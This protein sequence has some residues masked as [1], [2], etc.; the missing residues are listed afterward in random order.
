MFLKNANI[1]IKN[2]LG[3]LPSDSNALAASDWSADGVFPVSMTGKSFSDLLEKNFVYLES[4]KL[5]LLMTR[6]PTVSYL[7]S[8]YCHSQE[9]VRGVVF[10][11]GSAAPAAEDFKLSGEI[12]AGLSTS[13]VTYVFDYAADE[14]GGSITCVYTISNTTGADITIGEVGLVMNYGGRVVSTSST[15]Y[16]PVLVERSVLADP[17]TIPADGV[18]QVT[19]TIH[20]DSLIST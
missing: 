4:S 18:G 17:I 16:A 20:L 3:M 11:S 13:N 8:G 7:E 15:H 10:G 19:Y 6:F 9:F 12:I 2:L 5:Y 14:T 1:F